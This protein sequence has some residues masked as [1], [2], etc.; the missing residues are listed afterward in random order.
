MLQATR[1]ATSA[2]EATLRETAHRAQAANPPY[3][4]PISPLYL[5]Y[6]SQAAERR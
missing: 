2:A 1:A 4:S 3:I 6:I 5:P